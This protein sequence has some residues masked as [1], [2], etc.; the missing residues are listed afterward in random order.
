M[1]KDLRQQKPP[2]HGPTAHSQ[3]LPGTRRG[4]GSRRPPKSPAPSLLLLMPTRWASHLLPAK[5]PRPR[6]G[7]GKAGERGQ[8]SACSH[9]GEV[10][11]SEA[12][13][14]RPEEINYP[15]LL[16]GKG[17]RGLREASSSD[18]GAAGNESGRWHFGPSFPFP[19]PLAPNF[20]L[21]IATLCISILPF[22]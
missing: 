7:G 20:H 8:E 3:A 4:L 18:R 14:S 2:S 16:V 15:A 13:G 17:R 11:S 1:V 12:G 6:L 19:S 9:S 10:G 21:L 5:P 22:I